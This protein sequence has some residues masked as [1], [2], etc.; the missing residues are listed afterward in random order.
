MGGDL[1]AFKA[2]YTEMNRQANGISLVKE[3]KIKTDAFQVLIEQ[4]LK[5]QRP[6]VP[7]HWRACRKSMM[8]MVSLSLA[9]QT[10]FAYTATL[11]GSG[12]MDI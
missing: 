5:N 6:S 7:Q 12:N 3:Y 8:K 11:M 1:E 4:Q 9:H 2:A 10:A